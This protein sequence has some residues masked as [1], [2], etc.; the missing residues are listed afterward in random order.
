MRKALLALLVVAASACGSEPGAGQAHTGPAAACRV[1]REGVPL[2]RGVS[3]SSGV[4]FGRRNPGAVWTHNDS[5]G[6]AVVFA[7]D[8]TGRRFSPVEVQGA[9]NRDWE[10]IAVGSCPSGNCLFIADTGDN[11]AE[12]KDVEIIR[13]P[14][15]GRGARRTAPA[16]TFQ[17]RYPGGPRDA[18]AMFV[19]P[20]G[21]VYLLTKGRNSPVAL[22]RYPGPLRA[23]R[24]ATLQRVRSITRTPV[25]RPNQVTGADAT[26][27]GRWVAVRTYSSLFLYRTEDLFAGRDAAAARVDLARL[28]EPQG[29]GVA[30]RADGTVLLTS[31]GGRKGVRA[32][33]ARLRCTLRAPASVR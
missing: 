10:D 8:S 4:A 30:L 29:E 15:P 7:A 24:V 18:E 12:R 27:D 19:L 28:G 33:A 3:E 16:E 11:H 17:A 26:P 14:E 22:Y 9:R 6:D 21:R 32:S 25:S 23:G 20:G 1:R 2:S 13:V 31:E 5:G